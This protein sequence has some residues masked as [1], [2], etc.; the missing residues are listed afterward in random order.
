MLYVFEDY[1]LDMRRYELRRAGSP[2]SLDRQVFEV[3]AYLLAHPDQVVTRQELFTHLWPERCVSDAAL[4]RCITVARRALGDNGREQRCIKTVHGRGYRFVAA[5]AT[6]PDAE[7]RPLALASPL[8]PPS[9]GLT[10]GGLLKSSA[11]TSLL[12]AYCGVCK[13]PQPQGGKSCFAR[14]VSTNGGQP[15]CSIWRI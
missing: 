10:R 1:T 13:D 3:L 12:T 14:P 15:S 7:P 2:V 4:E 9:Q 5:V 8:P 6:H 11:V